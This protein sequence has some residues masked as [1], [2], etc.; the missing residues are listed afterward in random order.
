MYNC[1]NHSNQWMRV[2]VKI[3]ISTLQHLDKTE[4]IVIRKIV[5]KD[6]MRPPS[7]RCHPSNHFNAVL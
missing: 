1:I 2:W 6:Y 3:F 5:I 7:T 4:I